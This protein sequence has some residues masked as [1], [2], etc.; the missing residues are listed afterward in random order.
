[1][2]L[3]VLQAGPAVLNFG[4]SLYSLARGEPSPWFAK[5]GIWLFTFVVG[6]L[7]AP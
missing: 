2:C 4:S 6:G 3:T 1:M 5:G 7:V